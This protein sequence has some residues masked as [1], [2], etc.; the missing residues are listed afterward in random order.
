MSRWEGGD[1]WAP[2]RFT[3]RVG[4]GAPP[5]T[6]LPYTMLDPFDALGSRTVQGGTAQAIVAP[7]IEGT[8]ALQ[9][10]LQGVQNASMTNPNIG[11]NEAPTAWDVI[12]FAVDFGNSPEAHSAGTVRP[13]ITTN[14]VAYA[15]QVDTAGVGAALP[16]HGG[17]NTRGVRY[18]SV[19]ASRM[20]ATNFAGAA[21]TSAAAGAKSVALQVQ[22]LATGDYASRLKI[23]A[24]MLPAAHKPVIVL[25]FDDCNTRQRSEA[26]A[27]LQTRG[28]AATGYAGMDLFGAGLKLTLAEA[29]ELKN[30]FGWEWALNSG[31]LDEPMLADASV[32]A[33]I[34]RL[35]A[36]KDALIASGLGTAAS[37]KHVCFSYGTTAYRSTA[38][39]VSATCNGTNTVTL[40]G[41]N[42]WGNAVAAGMVVKGTTLGTDPVV[43]SAPTQGT[44]VLS[45]AVPS[46]T[47]TLTFCANSYG[48][49]TTCNG[50]TTVA[51]NSTGLVPGQLMTGHT[52]PPGTTIVSV[53]VDSASG[54][55]TVSNPVPATCTRADFHL[56][57]GEFFAGKLDDALLAAGY[58][59]GRLVTQVGGVYTGF[60]LDPKTAIVFPGYS[61][62]STTY[63]AARAIADLEMNIRNRADTICYQHFATAHDAAH[64]VAV[65]DFI[66]AR[67][68]AGEVDVLTIT[69]WH[70]RVSQRTF[71]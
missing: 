62:D 44:V 40:G 18:K 69:Q 66:Q 11:I 28:L 31:S 15:E 36:H 3:R 41:P 32:A 21:L 53:D 30:T 52:V 67:V 58:L 51:C 13:T 24:M 59:S 29:F 17:R 20:R 56:T 45:A 39:S 64:S 47:R 70:D 43:L 71:A 1:R 6:V 35:N 5:L 12:V 7:V 68:A 42:A 63:T 55:I 33:A 49:A 34:T 61:L 22:Q 26:A 4:G 16:T 65:F 23:D 54:S 50:T 27:L 25:T 14:S 60:G 38:Y 19:A 8:G 57:S 37:A 46:G 10:S 9:Y 48:I 2:E